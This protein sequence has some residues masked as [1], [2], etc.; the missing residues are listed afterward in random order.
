[1]VQLRDWIFEEGLYKQETVRFQMPPAVQA[2]VEKAQLLLRRA[3][4]GRRFERAGAFEV[5]ENRAVQAFNRLVFQEMLGFTDLVFDGPTYSL[6]PEVYFKRMIDGVEWQ[7]TSDLSIGEFAAGRARVVGVTEL[8]GADSDLTAPQRGKGYLSDHTGR[9]MSPIEQAIEA[10]KA[11]SCE[12]AL[13]SNFRRIC[14]LHKSDEEHALTYDLTALDTDGM[15][16]FY[17][18]FGPGGF[19]PDDRGGSRLLSLQG[20]VRRL[21][22]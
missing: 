6:L 12:W 13:V 20:R 4:Y 14:L 7:G 3:W 18:A 22:T 11:A 5:T 2:R 9:Q 8:K 16:S 19:Y 10:M 1:M 15:R 21:S 17:F